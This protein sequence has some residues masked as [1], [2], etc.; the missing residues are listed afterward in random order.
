MKEAGAAVDLERNIPWLYDEVEKDG[1]MRTREAIM[2]V[3]VNFP[4]TWCTALVDVSIR[5]PHSERYNRA[6]TEPALTSRNGEKNKDTR[7]GSAVLPLVFETY[8]RLGPSSL[9][10][11]RVLAD[12]SAIA[13]K[14][15]TRR[16]AGWRKQLERAV[17]WSASDSVL[18]SYGSGAFSLLYSRRERAQCPGTDA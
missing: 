6:V 13:R 2:D 8:G 15:S 11:L 10:T 5:C 4:G 18:Q 17:I 12:A 7:Y 9:N 1:V 3:V 16:M 14:A